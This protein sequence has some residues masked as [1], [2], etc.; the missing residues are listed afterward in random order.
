MIVENNKD[1][2]KKSSKRVLKATSF[3]GK[4]K[5]GRFGKVG[6]RYDRK[7]N[8]SRR[9][10]EFTGKYFSWGKVG[11]IKRG[12]PEKATVEDMKTQFSPLG[13]IDRQGG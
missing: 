9:F 3:G 6:K 8:G 10:G 5:N 2:K 13:K 7:G 1:Q 12:C 11:H 4:G